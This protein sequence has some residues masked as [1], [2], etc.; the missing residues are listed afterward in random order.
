MIFATRAD[1]YRD[2]RACFVRNI[3]AMIEFLEA[4]VLIHVQTAAVAAA[5]RGI[6]HM[7][8]HH[9]TWLA[10]AGPVL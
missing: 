4:N 9:T 8:G 7:P 3:G 10:K 1:R 5:N 2:S 6:L